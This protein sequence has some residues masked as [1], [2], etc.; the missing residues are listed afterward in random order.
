MQELNFGEHTVVNE[1][2]AH[3][4]APEHGEVVHA[5]GAVFL[6]DHGHAYRYPSCGLKQSFTSLPF[7]RPLCYL[8]S[9]YGDKNLW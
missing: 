1:S 8:F 4:P 2:P 7:Q 5:A 6:D 9:P 3:L